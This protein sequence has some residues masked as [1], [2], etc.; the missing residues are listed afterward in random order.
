M[1]NGVTALLEAIDQKVEAIAEEQERAEVARDDEAIVRVAAATGISPHTT[2]SSS[3]S[4]SSPMSS[5]GAAMRGMHSAQQQ[6]PPGSPLPPAPGR[7]RPFTDS[8]SAADAASSSSPWKDSSSGGGGG[9]GN[10][11]PTATA[12]PG[13]TLRSLFT[14]A[15]T[16][17]VN[18][19]RL[20]CASLEQA[21]AGLADE[22]AAA[23]SLLTKQRTAQE[24][25]AARVAAAE[26][27]KATW[28]REAVYYKEAATAARDELGRREAEAGA[29]GRAAAD[30]QAALESYR[31]SS[32]RMLEEK[33]R[34]IAALVGR[35]ANTN[36]SGAGVGLALGTGTDSTAAAAAA[37]KISRL[38]SRAEEAAADCARLQGLLAAADRDRQQ[39]Q[40]RQHALSSEVD[41]LR[42]DVRALAETLEGETA[43]REEAA[44]QLRRTRAELHSART[45]LETLGGGI[46]GATASTTTTTAAALG[47]S[48]SPSEPTAAAAIAS[49]EGALSESQQRGQVL[50]FQLLER[51]TA[52][53]ASG[54]EAAEWRAMYSA[55]A[56]RVGDEE[57]AAAAGFGK[58]A[59]NHKSRTNSGGGGSSISGLSFP[60]PPHASAGADR[61]NNSNDS[62]GGV[63]VPMLSSGGTAAAASSSTS[64]GC[65]D[66]RRNQAMTELARRGRGGRLVVDLLARIDE[67]ALRAAA[68]LRQR[69]VARVAV[70]A[71]V[72]FLQ[73]W[74]LLI[75]AV[76]LAATAAADES[77]Q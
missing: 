64:I 56:R 7:P 31:A 48:S 21:V 13:G 33:E 66:L 10:V 71:Y 46:R 63:A 50:S 57:I 29:M 27:A 51:Q 19:L 24:S 8:P 16:P 14:G 62:I 32:R 43:A 11:A 18:S 35:L 5:S 36:T 60:K 52:M 30:A 3:S 58:M 77:G 39:S 38:E 68:H 65:S 70:E 72:C 42:L 74:V 9:S 25:A 47:A 20:K 4:S 59:N 75:F 54:R 49:L 67:A 37:D 2:T 22:L 44:E 69:A 73:L 45:Q 1:F 40:Q 76:N 41:G 6:R 28:Q 26:A 34:E 55:L 12:S 23:E 15:E 61:H 53:E 17:P